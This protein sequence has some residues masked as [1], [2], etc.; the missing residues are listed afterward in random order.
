M[1]A[2]QSLPPPDPLI[3][4]GS[5]DYDVRPGEGAAADDLPALRLVRVPDWGQPFDGDPVPADTT[6]SA[7]GPSGCGLDHG[8]PGW[9]QA[10]RAAMGAGFQALAGLQIAA[11]TSAEAEP[12]GGGVPWATGTEQSEASSQW[13]RQFARLL[14]EA[15]AGARPV[16]QI[17]P[18]TSERARGHLGRLTPLFGGGQRP[19]V[20]RVITTMPTREVIEM[21][22]IVGVGT[23]TRALAVRLEQ[24]ALHR[25]ARP[26][27]YAS[28]GGTSLVSAHRWICT[29]IEAA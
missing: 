3:Q 17:L 18:W 7:G 20:L 8:D 28:R 12:D 16:R 26:A 29:D 21:T 10:A 6:A 2:S 14:T 5:P 15:L 1:P 24:A 25:L 27:E 22:V 19:R 4:D 11:D 13:A 9:G 23:R